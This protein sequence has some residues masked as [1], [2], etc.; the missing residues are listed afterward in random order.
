MV[1][2]LPTVEQERRTLAEWPRWCTLKVMIVV[3]KR[4]TSEVTVERVTCRSSSHEVVVAAVDCQTTAEKMRRR[5]IQLEKLVNCLK[6]RL[7]ANPVKSL[8]V[9]LGLPAVAML[10]VVAKLSFAAGHCCWR[11][12]PVDAATF[13]VEIAGK[14]QTL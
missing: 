4:V 1:P 11:K 10:F 2:S 7:I 5:R 8:L 13:E 12:S 3:A 14:K 9:P 6:R